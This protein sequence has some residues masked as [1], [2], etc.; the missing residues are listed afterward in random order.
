MP[1]ERSAGSRAWWV[2]AALLAGASWIAT[3]W[4]AAWLDWQPG[5]AL[6]EP[7][8]AWTAAFVHWSDL[9]L[10]VNLAAA[11]VV[12]ALGVAAALPARAAL[13]WLVA[14][15]LAH[16]GLALQPSLLHYG[17]LS[18]VLHAGVAV[19]AL[20][21]CA[22]ERGARRWIGAAVGAGL[23]VKVLLERPWGPPLAHPAAWDIAIAPLAHASGAVAG[24][25][26]GAGALWFSRPAPGLDGGAGP[27]PLAAGTAPPRRTTGSHG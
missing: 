7:W 11:A 14:W 6:H 20:W 21:L 22:R 8:R 1:L 18:G 2:L 10:W 19:A 25:L 9:H 24:L 16:L 12:A 23:I 26:C 27:A 15:P 3:W 17:G 13:A 5:L 4:P